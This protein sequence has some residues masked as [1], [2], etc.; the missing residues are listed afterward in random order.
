MNDLAGD[1]MLKG[2]STN[3]LPEM[4]LLSKPRVVQELKLCRF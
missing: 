3:F 2:T 4:E 1:V